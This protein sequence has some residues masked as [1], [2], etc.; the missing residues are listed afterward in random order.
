[1]ALG[2]GGREEVEDM[3]SNTSF[4]F[5]SVLE[6]GGRRGTLSSSPFVCVCRLWI[7]DLRVMVS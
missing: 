6:L 4:C 2:G 7:W 3:S 1:M 5:C